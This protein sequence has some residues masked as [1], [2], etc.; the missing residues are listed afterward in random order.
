MIVYLA[1]PRNQTQADYAAGMPVLLSFACWAD[2]LDKG[3]QQSFARLLIDSGAYSEYTTGKKVDVLRYRDWA[4]QW[5]DHADAIAG[6]DSISG[7]W[8]TSMANYQ[9]IP[10]SFP[11]FH[12]SDPP[13]LLP[14]LIAMATERKNWIG[15]G[16]TTPRT[17]KLRFV[18]DTLEQI[19]PG[20]HVH[21]WA[22][23]EYTRCRRLDSVDST[24]W[25]RDAMLLRAV[26]ALSH[27]AYAECLEI[28]IRRYQRWQRT[29]FEA[30]TQLT[31]FDQAA[32]P[33][34]ED[35]AC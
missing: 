23:R 33:Q 25:F 31:L 6:L 34:P 14:E 4:A 10:F 16:L 5:I 19:P 15:L 9:A 13:E 35:R 11:T 2:W 27:L 7:D 1:S 26:P 12:D 22:L 21:G 17:G 29:V 3:Y 32:G 20:I 18:R 8:K 30:P 24:N 28:V